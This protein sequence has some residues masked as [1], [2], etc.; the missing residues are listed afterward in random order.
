MTF[1]ADSSYRFDIEQKCNPSIIQ[2]FLSNS[3]DCLLNNQYIW[4]KGW[5]ATNAILQELMLLEKQ[6][7]SPWQPLSTS[8]HSTGNS[9]CSR[10]KSLIKPAY[11]QYLRLQWRELVLNP[12][13]LYGCMEQQNLRVYDVLLHLLVSYV[14]GAH[15]SIDD[16]RVGAWATWDLLDLDVLSNVHVI[17]FLPH[18]RSDHRADLPDNAEYCISPLLRE[19]LPAEELLGQASDMFPLSLAM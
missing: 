3:R 14:L 6:V 16:A 18:V 9:L 5:Y 17:A 8:T 2:E 13:V 4:L 10:Q 12:L 11:L 15:H 1:H 7:N 19:T